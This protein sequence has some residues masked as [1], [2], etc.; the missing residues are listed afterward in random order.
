MINLKDYQI[1][2]TLQS[3]QKALICR[4]VRISDGQPVILKILAGNYP[5][6]L[7]IARLRREF[8]WF[9]TIRV[10]GVPV[11]ESLEKE[12]NRHFLC[13]KDD[14]AAP[15]KAVFGDQPLEIADFLRFAIGACRVLANIHEHHI[16]HKN[17]KPDNLLIRLPDWQVLLIDYGFSVR[18]GDFAQE[19]LAGANFEGSLPYMSPEQTGRMNRPV[20][21]RS[22]LYAL[23]ITFYELLTGRLPFNATHPLEWA[24]AHMAQQPP[25]ARLERPEIPETL[26]KMISKL[27]AKMA[28]DRY[29]SAYG[30]Q[31][32]LETCLEQWEKYQRIDRFPLGTADMQGIFRLP[33]KLYG[34]EKAVKNLSDTVERVV[35]DGR[36][37]MILVSG[38]SG[39]GKTVLVQE[40][41]KQ[42]SA[43]NGYFITGKFDQ[44]NRG[45]PYQGFRLAFN[46]L[47]KQLLAETDKSLG[48]WRERLYEALGPN[49]Q[50]V[51]EMAP[52]FQWILGEYPPPPPLPTDEAA[53]RFLHTWRVF[54][55][56]VAGGDHPLVLFLDDLQWADNASLR[57][58]ELLL[59][60][61][62]L[63][64]L[65]F[66]GAYRDNEIRPAHP[67]MHL[68]AQ[69]QKN[70]PV[71]EIGLSP[72]ALEDVG[73]LLSDTFNATPVASDG[74]ARLLVAKTEGNPFFLTQSL[75]SLCEEGLIR[76]NKEKEAWNWDLERISAMN[77]TDNVVELLIG[78]IRR[79]SEDAQQI[80]KYA[81][82]I[83]NEFSLR[84]LLWVVKPEQLPALS[85]AVEQGLILPLNDNYVLLADASRLE[86]HYR[87]SPVA[88][89]PADDATFQFLHDR[90]QQAAS[91][92]LSEEE[93]N[94]V[95]AKIGYNLWL[96]ANGAERDDRIFE[97]CNH[98]GQGR[99]FLPEAQKAQLPALNLQAGKKALEAT[100]YG[101][102]LNYLEA[103]IAAL[104]PDAWSSVY[105]TCLDLYTDKAQGQYLGGDAAGASDTLQYALERSRRRVDKM[106]ILLIFVEMYTSQHLHEKAVDTIEAALKL[107]NIRLPRTPAALKFGLMKDAV[108]LRF[109]LRNKKA[110]FLENL[111]ENTDPDYIALFALFSAS[112]PVIYQFSQ[113]M[114]AWLILAQ[115]KICLSKGQTPFSVVS[116]FGYGMVMNAA[117]GDVECLSDYTR[118]AI[119]I[120]EKKGN[121]YPPQKLW[122]SSLSFEAHL[123]EAIAPRM[124]ELL[125]CYRLAL[126]FGDPVYG[127]YAI[128]TRIWNGL[129]L[130]KDLNDLYEEGAAYL[131]HLKQQ[132][133][134]NSY[135]M[136]YSRY[137]VLPVLMGRPAEGWLTPE[138]ISSKL[139]H[140]L[141]TKNTTTVAFYYTS[142]YQAFS[143]LYPAKMTYEYLAEGEKYESFLQPF[144]MYADFMLYYALAARQI[145]RHDATRKKPLLKTINRHYKALK[146][147]AG[148]CPANY[149]CHFL[150][151]SGV[152]AILNDLSGFALQQLE[153]AVFSAE[154]REFIQIAAISNELIAEHYI[155]Q[156]QRKIARLY[157]QESL[158]AWKRWGAEAK[159]RQLTE[160]Y[161]D[162]LLDQPGSAQPAGESN[163]DMATLLKS[164]TTISSEIVLEKLLPGMIHIVV[165]NAGAQKGYLM[166]AQD[167]Q[168][169]IS[170]YY[171][172]GQAAGTLL[173]DIPMSSSEKVPES[174]V[175]Y[176]WRTLEPLVLDFAPADERFKNDPYITAC[177]PKSILCTPVR[178]H[179]ELKGFIYLENNLMVRAFTEERVKV[180]RI[181]SAQIAVSLD[182]ALL[183]KNLEEALEKQVT[184]TE[185][186]SR[187]TPK[188]Y[189]RFLGHNSI[190]DVRLGDHR[191]ETMT[192]LFSDI[193]S[194]TALAEQLTAEENF[195]FLSAY[196]KQMSGVVTRNNGMVNQL[197][198][199]GI[200]AFFS[201]SGDALRAAVEMQMLLRDY[202]VDRPGKE[203]IAL[204]VGIG[205]HTGTVIIG[206]VGDEYR[207]DTGIVS[208]TVNA[209]SRIE[210]L[211][212]FYGVNILLSETVVEQLPVQTRENL[213]YLG[214]VRVKGKRENISLYECYD[215]DAPE[216][217]RRKANVLPGFNEALQQY[218]DRRFNEAVDGF[219]QLRQNDLED[220]VLEL[221]CKKAFQFAAQGVPDDWTGVESIEFK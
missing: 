134:I 14:G 207:M 9:Q 210:G 119:R 216:I 94:A 115:F 34:R 62:E 155:G 81:G 146:T 37:E 120:N 49:A 143:L 96:H 103:G 131:K 197:L 80:L 113:D 201:D 1:A 25:D 118:T 200:L 59:P 129:V 126:E 26:A 211:T 142:V 128:T 6:P 172:A 61:P 88:G 214:K 107:F 76:F 73:L 148:R 4:A 193:R 105:E 23:G 5:S 123:N 139:E 147:R 202:T 163:L 169:N 186:Y 93:R 11:F 111:P 150:L 117:F 79:L 8:N 212:K 18:V 101:P 77:I 3:N 181:L 145:I 78:N 98:L 151:V 153:K 125:Q 50:I 198:G 27:M 209:A 159:V 45:I 220:P 208:D 177:R 189:L 161:P 36:P 185:A 32:D 194:Y 203:P 170:A 116:Y 84:T 31:K 133:N 130:G 184:L 2:E 154:K 29:Q 135:E 30:L 191:D 20:D 38:Y 22:D 199:D 140:P 83:G 24:H 173:A 56:L 167:K 114:F 221:F 60:D 19:T 136:L 138:S 164:T 33:A 182:N 137:S 44:L 127:G 82:C 110:A 171:E 92:M 179:G 156:N 12:D 35:R 174:V 69:M 215:G 7:E 54:I 87:D 176:C 71:H 152:R 99:Y 124:D 72:L 132:K 102:A 75:K 196:L 39:I 55:K 41:Q 15:L 158:Y 157:L 108:L 204:K 16:I 121:P 64:S 112:A 48:V 57:L 149:E 86:E 66:I 40:A 104:P 10:E 85:E 188:E 178:H 168:L 95:H 219:Q 28:E 21:N 100:A 17:I 42:I 183:Y 63:Q 206:I 46:E 74:L 106:R 68:V 218:F 58:L 180:M 122:Y 165:E 166:L 65:C 91:S 190:L 160:L 13:M 52:G 217:R 109:R 43:V 175:N 187:F 90:V 97:I 47:A 162:L 51:Q 141:F 144:Y 53:N 70:L 67:L 205:L 213:R 195:Q 89:K 192:V